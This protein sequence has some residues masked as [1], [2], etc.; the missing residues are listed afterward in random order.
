MISC[1]L[2]DLDDQTKSSSNVIVSLDFILRQLQ[3]KVLQELEKYLDNKITS[4]VLLIISSFVLNIINNE[5]SKSQPLML[6]FSYVLT[7]KAQLFY[8]IE[9]YFCRIMDYPIIKLV[10]NG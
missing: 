8:T 6:L 10:F 5:P 4:D 1:Q 3:M 2:A 9:I 7:F